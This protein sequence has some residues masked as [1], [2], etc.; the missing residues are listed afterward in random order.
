[1]IRETG[2]TN[3]IYPYP[4][5]TIGEV[6]SG[7]ISG[8]STSY[9][10]F[11]NWTIGEVDVLCESS[12]EE[13][14]AEVNNVADEDITAFP[15][16]HT[17][18]SSSYD[19]NYSGL[20]GS[21]CGSSDA[22]LDGYDVVY[23]YAAD[24]DYLLEINLTGLSETHT[25][26]FV[27]KDCAD[28]GTSCAA[29]GSV[30]DGSTDDHG[31]ELAVED[32]EDYYIVVSS[33]LP[34]ESFDY[35]LTVDAVL[36]SNMD[37]PIGDASQ[38]FFD[39]QTVGDLT[40]DGVGLTWYSD[41]AL[42][43]VIAD[44]D[45]ELLVDNTTYYVTQSIDTCEGQALAITVT[46]TPCTA[47]AVASTEGAAVCGNGSVVL[48][49]QKT[50]SSSSVDIF[51]YDSATGGNK[52]GAGETFETPALTQTTSFWAAEVALT[53]GELAG[54][55]KPTY[56]TVASTN[57]SNWGLV[58]DAYNA[59]TIIDVE[60]YSTGSGGDITI[61]LQDDSGNMI[62]SGVFN[63]PGGG[64][65]SNPIPA[66]L[67]LNFD[68]PAAGEYRLIK[69]SSGVNMI[70]ESGTTN[71]IYPYPLGTV[72]EVT[73]GYISGTST[74]YYW[75]YN[76]TIGEVD[77]LCESSREE[78]IAEV[79]N[80]ADEIVSGSIPYT[81]TASTT[82]YGNNYAG[83]AGGSCDSGNYLDG[84]DVVYQFTPT[85]GAVYSIELSGL[86][87][88]EMGVFVFESC[89]DIGSDCFAG[90]VSDGTTSDF[91][92]EDVLL[93]ENTD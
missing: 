12:R 74:S 82:S 75:F 31:F 69:T 34:T 39:G 47:L 13:V 71:N 66:T 73:S 44:T 59:F 46:E 79:N 81:H 51:W 92:V 80:V 60:V 93:Q 26:V 10:W 78:V 67:S 16:S 15:Y 85:T 1:M 64:S 61:E 28:I 56:T 65:T 20:P 37:A 11:Y 84:Y 70:R 91:G 29:E 86:T 3:N 76:W 40:V 7:Y 50:N 52:V 21:N 42:T 32:G 49:A 36:C 19:N 33:S 58:F 83:E 8:T 68:V 6:T 57:G 55:G 14:I 4:L 43:T 22:Y 72:G 18:N 24:D 77:V 87:D 90:A 25:S 63:V 17:A 2:T 62:E 54:Q 45:L 41:A 35:T 48:S 38:A 88:D 5:G 23:H 9:Y 27:Y 89:S 53:G 30:N